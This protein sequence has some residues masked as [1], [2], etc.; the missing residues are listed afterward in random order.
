MEQ[1]KS[2][3]WGVPQPSL[4]QILKL[5]VLCNLKARFRVI[6]YVIECFGGIET[7]ESW[8]Y[9]VLV[10]IYREILLKVYYNVYMVV[11]SLSNLFIIMYLLISY[12]YGANC[13]L[14]GGTQCKIYEF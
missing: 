1:I 6:S 5:S 7:N 10:V 14:L 3:A 9:V 4:G 13:R 12:T 11:L 8:W 2:S